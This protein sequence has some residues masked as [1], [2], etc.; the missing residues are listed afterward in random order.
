MGRG[1]NLKKRQYSLPPPP[2]EDTKQEHTIFI[3]LND[4]L[5]TLLPALWIGEDHLEAD[6]C[7]RWQMVHNVLRGFGVHVQAVC[8][9]LIVATEV[10]VADR[11]IES[12]AASDVVA[13]GLPVHSDAPCLDFSNLQS[14]RGPHGLCKI[15]T[16]SCQLD[17]KFLL[18]S[19]VLLSRTQYIQS[20]GCQENLWLLVFCQE[21][22]WVLMFCLFI[23][24][25]W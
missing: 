19:E 1:V 4:R 24:S 6:V 25:C 18:E 14:L 10:V 5:L 7:I 20:S 23:I 21:N 8:P 9:A 12:V 3:S 22:L 15:N 11:D 16:D 2:C 13:Q 17:C